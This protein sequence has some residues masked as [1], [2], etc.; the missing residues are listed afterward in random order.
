MF[1]VVPN[2]LDSTDARA[3]NLILQLGTD[4]AGNAVRSMPV[5]PGTALAQAQ[6]A[7]RL[8]DTDPGR[9][10]A[11]AARAA[12]RAHREGDPVAAALA[13][14]AWGHSLL[15]R[16]ELTAAI[17]TLRRS[18][19][20]G[21]Q[22]G[23]ASLTGEARAKLAYAMVMR[24][25]PQAALTE[26]DAALRDLDGVPDGV[27]A[28]RARAQR[29][30]ILTEIGRFDEALADFQRALPVLRAASDQ[31][32]VA[33]MLVNRGILHAHRH[34]FTA[35]VRDLRTAER[36]S[37]QLGRELA[38]GIITQ[39][40][41]FVETLRGDVPAALSY[42]DRAERV[43]G[44]HAGYVASVHQ[45][46]AELLLSVGLV[47][48]ARQAAERA[49]TAYQRE[50]RRLKVPEAR[51][52]LAQT[53]V[54][55]GDWPAAGKHAT[56]A[57]REFERQRRA[58]WAALARTAA[59]RARLAAGDR[60]GRQPLD[61]MVETLTSAGWPAAAVEA[62]L[63][64]AQVT[65]RR[66]RDGPAPSGTIAPSEPA[67]AYLSQASR[68]G[69]RRGPATL[70]ARGWYAEALLRLGRGQPASAARAIR[71][72]LRVLDEHGAALGA[73]DLRVHSAMHRRELTELGLRMALRSGRVSQIFEWAERARASRLAY[74]QVR[75]AADPYLADLLSQL[76]GVAREIDRS[77]GNTRLVRRQVE[78]E[79]LIRDHHRLRRGAAGPTVAPV[80]PGAL[81]AALGDSA[82]LEFVQHDGVL[83]G[84]SMAGGRLRIRTIGP[85]AEIAALVERLPFA[86]HRLASRTTRA[87][88]LVASER[89]LRETAAKLDAR[90]LRPFGELGDRPL[91][92]V[93]TGPLHSVPWSVLPSCVGR[94]VLVSP[95]ATLWHSTGVDGRPVA[96][97]GKGTVAGE[98]AVAAGPRLS[99]A[100]EEARAVAAIHRTTSL[101]DNA[102]TVEAVL[103]ALAT[104]GV[105]H[106]AAHGLLSASNPLF[107]ELLLADGPLVVY[108]L[109][110]LTRVPHTVV[111]AACDTGRPVVRTGDELLGLSAALIG[112]G[113]TQLVASVLPIPDVE[114]AP[115]MV[116]FHRRLAAGDPPT[117]ALAAAQHEQRTAGPAALAAAAGFVCLGSR[118]GSPPAGHPGTG[119]G[120]VKGAPART[121]HRQ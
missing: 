97:A 51:L 120:P 10:V 115:L 72:G 103:A 86:V 96:A 98:V 50:R 107:S 19:G 81:G 83:H 46:R 78:L 87:E 82:L 4:I 71:T 29:A 58:E 67:A 31:L 54:A 17:R 35:A 118:P 66:G 80:A 25:R 63:V 76:R 119:A 60:I 65:D 15:Q 26:I 106:L 39:N 117:V 40:L 99:G 8:A 48:E 84:L 113:T 85:A 61:A 100:R 38:V 7:V 33:R 74:R 62:R 44:A 121:R 5:A 68:L 28:A 6:D 95:S 53:A 37:R 116:A 47:T 73:T 11:T 23:S 93:P 102:A 49:V 32:G 101:V 69:R 57:M 89:L 41:G 64:A 42:L 104:A 112:R 18:V 13:H 9:A 92:I 109:E 36:L 55:A 14:R 111:L 114:T 108:D 70:R 59:L 1:G 24:G 90:L 30:V 105:I 79:R 77:G 56:E 3:P 75:P 43:I 2:P 88:S 91:V 110:Q 22:A 12:R 21:R 16:G 34:A 20:Y 27:A 45:D 52:L 94:P